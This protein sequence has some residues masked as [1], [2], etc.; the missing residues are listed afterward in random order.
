MDIYAGIA[1]VLAL[2]AITISVYAITNHVIYYTKPYLQRYIIRVILMVPIYSANA[3]LALMMP[4]TSL[5]FDSFREIYE[6]FVIYSFMKYLFNYLHHDT[7]LQQYIDFKPGPSQVFPLCCLPNCV[8]GH[9]LLIRCKHGILQYVVIRPLTTIIAF[10]SQI[11]NF[12]GEGNYNPFS[13]YVFPVLLWVNNG[14]QLLAMYCLV[15]FY[16]GYRQELAPMQPLAKFFCIKLVVFFSFFQQVA[17]A[18]LMEF[19]AIEEFFKGVFPE[20]ND[21]I[22]ISRKL[23]EFL[24]CIDMF[25]ASIAHNF[26]F[27]HKPFVSDISSGLNI[28]SSSLISGSHCSDAHRSYREALSNILDFTDDKRDISDHLMEVR[29]RVRRMLTF[30]RQQQSAPNQNIVPQ[31]EQ[32]TVGDATQTS[33]VDSGTHST[34]PKH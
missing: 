33:S 2:G 20:L 26:A 11:F 14:S 34:T 28:E 9:L 13:G 30:S 1:T 17:I 19:N 4:V 7:N 5:Y 31:D 32:L 3:W 15:I 21:K 10:T 12:Y 29:S 27:S 18:G 8:G 16:T 23:T 25:V 6:S 22:L 24:I